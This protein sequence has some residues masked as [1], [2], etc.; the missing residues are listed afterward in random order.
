M[1]TNIPTGEPI[2]VAPSMDL[3][4]AAARTAKADSRT[5]RVFL[6]SGLAIVV[7]A[8]SAGAARILTGLIGLITNLVFYGRVS[9]AFSSPADNHL[10]ALVIV[11]PVIGGLIVGIMARYGSPAIR[12]H[13]IPEA[14]EQVLLNGSRIPPRV[15]FLKP[16]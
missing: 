11:I 12:G 5:G 8:L 13:G 6:L 4:L 1:G 9:A 14:M 2:P 15:T 7:A 16:L 10:G 3:A